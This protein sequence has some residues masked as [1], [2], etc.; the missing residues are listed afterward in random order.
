MTRVNRLLPDRRETDA[1]NRRANTGSKANVAPHPNGCSVTVKEQR[2]RQS[3]EWRR[4]PRMRPVP[5]GPLRVETATASS[6][7][8]GCAPR[9]SPSADA[10]VNSAA[11]RCGATPT[12]KRS[13]LLSPE[14]QQGKVRITMIKRRLEELN[15]HADDEE[16][17]MEP[18]KKGRPRSD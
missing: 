16:R 18:P 13:S 14:T 2:C 10:F 11:S 7:G 6:S 3:R 4:R 1:I 12:R 17:R 15:N 9:A 5:I 8:A